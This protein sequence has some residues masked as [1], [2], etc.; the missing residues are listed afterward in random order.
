MFLEPVRT[1]VQNLIRN[2]ARLL[3]LQ[4]LFGVITAALLVSPAGAPRASLGAGW[5]LVERRGLELLDA[6]QPHTR[7]TLLL[8]GFALVDARSR[9]SAANRCCPCGLLDHR[10]DMP[11]GLTGATADSRRPARWATITRRGSTCPQRE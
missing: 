3:A 5:C 10:P 11:K 4:V 9:R 7:S 2:G 6:V 1:K 8:Q